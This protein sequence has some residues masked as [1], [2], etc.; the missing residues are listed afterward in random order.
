MMRLEN[1]PQWGAPPFRN[2]SAS[3][4]G[5]E[6]KGTDELVRPTTRKLCYPGCEVELVRDTAAQVLL[7]QAR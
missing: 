5:H 7:F 2:N 3:T 4:L 1:N 6:K